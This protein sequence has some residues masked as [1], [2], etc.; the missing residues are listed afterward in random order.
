MSFVPKPQAPRRNQLFTPYDAMLSQRME[1]ERRREMMN[2]A[3]LKMQLAGNVNQ[4]SLDLARRL[5]GFG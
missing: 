4:G 1:E 3:R 5:L 2:L